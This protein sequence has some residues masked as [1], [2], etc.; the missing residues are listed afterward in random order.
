MMVNKCA[1]TI[2][3]YLYCK[4][5]ATPADIIIGFGHFDLSIAEKC[6]Q[7]YQKG[8]SS[9]ILLTGG[10]GAGTAD[11]PKPEADAFYDHIRKID[12]GIPEEAIIIEN[13][14]TN[15]A[16]NIRFSNNLL[17]KEY[18]LEFQKGIHSALIIANPYRQ[19]RVDLTCKKLFPSVSYF[20]T[21]PTSEFE[22]EKNKFAEK[23]FD[24]IFLL[25]GEIERIK[26]YGKN[27]W[28]QQTTIPAEIE[29]CYK[30]LVDQG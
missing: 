27:G 7:L 24:L 4:E 9:K 14:S 1:E 21:P 26:E 15:T 11:L 3:N 13:K 5:D 12:P 30:T 10:I 29:N 20:N 28:I 8:L 23:G 18:E 17:K 2:F 6:L 16:E 22:T 19:R 25:K